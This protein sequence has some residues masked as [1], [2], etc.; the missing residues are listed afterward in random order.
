MSDFT[1]ANILLQ[2]SVL[3]SLSEEEVLEAPGEPLQ[4]EVLTESGDIPLDSTAPKYL[5]RA[6]DFYSV[7]TRKMKNEPCII[8]F[9]ESFEVAHPPEDLGIPQVYCSP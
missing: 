9:G 3:D 7:D 4:N 5:V 8:S 6:V 1:P 2:V